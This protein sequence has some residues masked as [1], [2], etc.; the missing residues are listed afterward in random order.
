MLAPSSRSV[1]PYDTG[2]VSALKIT[3]NDFQDPPIQIFSHCEQ[4]VLLAQNGWRV[5]KEKAFSMILLFS[6]RKRYQHRAKVNVNNEVPECTQTMLQRE[7]I[8]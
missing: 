4:F 6:T 7:Q 5:E 8:Q 1:A 2:K 3:E